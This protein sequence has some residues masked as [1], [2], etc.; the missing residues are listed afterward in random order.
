MGWIVSSI[1]LNIKQSY[2]QG[3]NFFLLQKIET[4]H[5]LS[6]DQ[7]HPVRGDDDHQ[8]E[9][10]YLVVL[11]LLDNYTII[12]MVLDLRRLRT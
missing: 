1:N 12:Q 8:H 3:V 9:K 7:C 10:D 5:H 2:D 4:T 11:D 6:F